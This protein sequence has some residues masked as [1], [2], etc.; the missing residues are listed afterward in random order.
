MQEQTPCRSS[1]FCPSRQH[2][3]WPSGF[4]QSGLPPISAV[5]G[6]TRRHATQATYS[7]A[8]ENNDSWPTSEDSAASILERG[9]DAAV[10]QTRHARLPCRRM[11]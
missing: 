6:A 1:P 9:A 2:L 4:N 8:L 5:R 11:F 10:V 7:L 3:H